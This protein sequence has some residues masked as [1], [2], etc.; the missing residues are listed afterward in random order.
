M[1]VT[2]EG[3]NVH[4]EDVERALR[5]Q[6]GVR[7]AVVLGKPGPRGEEVWGVLLLEPGGEAERAIGEANRSLAPHQRLRGFTVWPETDFPRTPTLKPRRRDIAAALAVAPAPAASGAAPAPADRLARLLARAGADPGRLRDDARLEDLGLSSL[8][9]VDL[10]AA[11]EEEFDLPVAD[12]ALGGGTSVADLRRLLAGGVSTHAHLAEV[13]IPRWGMTAPMRLFGALVR[14]GLVHPTLS[15]FA[16]LTVVGAGHLTALSPPVLFV[17][18]HVSLVDVPLLARALPWR[19]RLRLAPA[20]RAGH[21]YAWFRP[22]PGE[23]GLRISRGVQFVLAAAIFQAFPLP[24]GEGFRRALEHAGALADRGLCPLVFPEGTRGDG[25]KLLPFQAGTGLMALRL[26]L[27]V[28][29]LLHEGLERVL[30]REA[31][32][33]TRAATRVRI[34]PPVPLAG[35]TDP[36]AAARRIEAAMRELAGG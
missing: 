36:E 14:E 22:S 27:P 2:A 20:I 29:P 9:L 21:F 4:P 8:D 25:D 13:P 30:S 5:S 32:F 31:R 35:I 34:G 7:D 10:G 3:L 16:P 11:F 6:P 23:L 1:I 26:G 15:L 28:V 24:Q 12:S 17:A 33:P 19:F 18:N